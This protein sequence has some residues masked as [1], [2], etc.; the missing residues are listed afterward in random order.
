VTRAVSAAAALVLGA[1]LLG[2]GD[3]NDDFGLGTLPASPASAASAASDASASAAASS[4]SSPAAAV[5]AIVEPPPDSSPEDE[6][7]VTAYRAFW[8]S[9]AHALG[10][11]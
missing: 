4:P 2:C 3:S 8:E 7:V 6:D 11:G 5:T 9:Y 1:V 10:T